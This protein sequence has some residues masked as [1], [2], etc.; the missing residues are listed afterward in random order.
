MIVQAMKDAVGTDP[1][2]Y[3]KDKYNS[4]KKKYG[5]ALVV[6][7]GDKVIL[8]GENTRANRKSLVEKAQAKTQIPGP[9]A[10]IGTLDGIR[11]GRYTEIEKHMHPALPEPRTP[12]S[13]SYYHGY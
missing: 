4:L 5:D 2:D 8:S 11:R 1:K 6:V 9:S 13:H 10:I 7:Y 3:V 12:G